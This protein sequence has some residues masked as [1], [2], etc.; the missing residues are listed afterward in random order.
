MSVRNN[1]ERSGARK[2]A[3]PPPSQMTSPDVPTNTSDKL[4]FTT[5]TEFV[6][7]PSIGKYYPDD[8]PLHNA[9]SV[10]IRYMTAK[11][12][13]ILTSKSFLKKGI[14]IDRFLQNIIVDPAVKVDQLLIGDKN[15]L[16]VAARITGYGSDYKTKVQCPACA[17]VQ[18]YEF[19]LDS[20]EASPGGES[21]DATPTPQNTWLVDCPKSTATVELRLL[22][23]ADE[24]KLMAMQQMKKRNKLPE[25]G[26]TD[27]LRLIIK[28]VNG[29]EEQKTINGFINSMP[30]I[31]SRYVRGVY[32]QIMPNVDLTQHFECSECS[33]DMKMEVPFTTDFFWPKR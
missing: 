22:T 32:D 17:T 10:E 7:L 6:D 9:E 30:A 20:P 31:D 26:A 27:Q 29:S 28:S 33:F 15:A 11:D 12:E 1:E 3:A 4:N 23:G 24:K 2:A 8:H 13:D 16:I 18:E 21:M 5:P 25:A 19:S 14:A